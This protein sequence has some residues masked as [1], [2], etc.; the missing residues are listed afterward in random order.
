MQRLGK[1]GAPHEVAIDF[2]SAATAFV[3]GPY[4][5]GLATAAVATGEDALDS[6]IEL[7]VISL[8]IGTGVFLNFEL[9]QDSRFRP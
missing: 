6:A 5:E 3:Y 1:L 9:I 2:A 8:G 7:A 4:D